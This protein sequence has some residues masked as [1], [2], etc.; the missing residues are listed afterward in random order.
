MRARGQAIGEEF[1]G[2]GIQWVMKGC[3]FL[4]YVSHLY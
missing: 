4:T 2:K 3:A 1:R